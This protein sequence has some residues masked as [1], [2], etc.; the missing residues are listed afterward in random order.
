M[1]NKTVTNVDMGSVLIGSGYFYDE[2][3][4]VSE[5]RELPAGLILARSTAGA[6]D[7]KL[8]PYVDGGADGSGT[9]GFVLTYDVDATNGDN[10]VRVLISGPVDQNRL[11]VDGEDTGDAITGALRD[12]LRRHDIIVQDSDQLSSYD[13]Q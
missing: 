12:Q 13:N 8:V 5:D 3:I 11:I 10:A 7:G 6:T 1:A 4:A 2:V 9:P